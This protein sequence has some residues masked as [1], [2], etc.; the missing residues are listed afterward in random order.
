MST[1]EW[2]DIPEWIKSCNSITFRRNAV[3]GIFR[4]NSN[5]PRLLWALYNNTT[6]SPSG[7]TFADSKV[8][9]MKLSAY[10]AMM[11][12]IGRKIN[13]RRKS[14]DLLVRDRDYLKVCVHALT[15]PHNLR[16]KKS[17]R[18]RTRTKNNNG[19]S[20]V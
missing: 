11:S 10:D 19:H 4:I 15:S 20:T 18:Q 3:A 17:K 14:L 8:R 2:D 5:D 1:D 13:R 12:S 7:F 9:P 6:A 16:W